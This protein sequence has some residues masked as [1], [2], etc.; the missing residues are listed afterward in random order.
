[1]HRE[2]LI[3]SSII[4]YFDNKEESH[5]IKIQNLIEEYETNLQNSSSSNISLNIVDTFIALICLQGMSQLSRYEKYAE[6]QALPLALNR[7]KRTWFYFKQF[8][9]NDSDFNLQSD[10]FLIIS[11]MES[12]MKAF[13]SQSNQSYEHCMSFSIACASAW[14]KF[15]MWDLINKFHCL[16]L[17]SFKLNI[18]LGNINKS[19]SFLSKT[20]NYLLQYLRYERSFDLRR[21][22]KRSITNRNDF[23]TNVFTTTSFNNN[24]NSFICPLSYNT[25][26]LSKTFS[27]NEHFNR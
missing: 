24:I 10:E 19:I 25:S 26:I 12:T 2:S 15:G 27:T 23:S 9:N 8:F 6:Y 18:I 14:K 1:M 21:R 3:L 20:K 7:F 17:D 4:H 11:E 13:F 16:L 5:S 22:T